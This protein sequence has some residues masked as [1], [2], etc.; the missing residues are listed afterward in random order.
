MLA[1]VHVLTG[2]V[3]SLTRQASVWIDAVHVASWQVL[4]QEQD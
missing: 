2:S 1:W 3:S 4:R